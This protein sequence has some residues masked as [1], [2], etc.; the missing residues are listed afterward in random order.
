MDRLVVFL[1]PEVDPTGAGYNLNQSKIAVGSG[2]LTGKGLL[3][4]LLGGAYSSTVTTVVLAKKSRGNRLSRLYSGSILLASGLMY[5]RLVVLVAAFN[6]NLARRIMVPFLVLA[7]LAILGGLVWARMERRDTEAQDAPEPARNPLE[8]R[9][10]FF[11]ALIFV[12]VLVTSELVFESVGRNGLYLLALIMG[13]T[14]VDPF[15]M[16]LTSAAGTA[17]PLDVAAAGV[18]IAASSNNIAKGLYAYTFSE[19]PTGMPSLALLTLLAAAGLL[20]LLW[21][22]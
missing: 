22:A 13:V 9:A 18:V 20:P 21:I 11:F 10:A 4:A 12:A 3:S 8:F 17:T 2:Q 15:I 1:N 5:L 7:A 6:G 19:R 16:G 14:D